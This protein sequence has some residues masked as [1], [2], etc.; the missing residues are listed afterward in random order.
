[1]T[2][3]VAPVVGAAL[4]IAPLALAKDPPQPL[5]L[6]A[7]SAGETVV[8][9]EPLGPQVTQFETGPVG[10]LYEA[11]G[12]ALFAPDLVNGRTTVIDLRTG[13]VAD[14]FDGVTMPHFAPAGDRYVV[15]ADDVLLVSYPERAVMTRMAAGIRYP[16]QVEMV[17]DTVLLVLERGPDGNGAATLHAVDLATRQVV[18]RRELAG[19]VRRFALSRALGLLAFADASSGTVELVLPATLTPVGSLEMGGG[20]R[21]VA[22]LDSRGELAAVAAAADG[23]SGELKVWKLK[24]TDGGLKV[25]KE[26]ALPLPGTPVR[27]AIAPDERQLA[28]ALD[29]GSILVVDVDELVVA[30]TLELV[31]PPRDLVWCDPARP[32]PVLPDWSD[33]NPP[34]LRLGPR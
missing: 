8:L 19:D 27:L 21:D 34:E 12:G 23:T 33:D 1:M 2:R 5:G 4:L 13:Q 10:W 31:S 29:P 32:G 15:V 30:R 9:A 28:V 7:A 20:V 14:R 11:P 17:S 26:R 16:W 18:F 6:L 25:K 24:P 22:Y 3:R